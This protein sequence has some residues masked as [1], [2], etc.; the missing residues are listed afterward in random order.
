M[1]VAEEL[2]RTLLLIKMNNDDNMIWP[3]VAIVGLFFF[4]KITTQS[5]QVQLTSL[6]DQQASQNNLWLTVPGAVSAGL[7]GVG[8]LLDSF[9]NLFTDNSITD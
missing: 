6:A 5:Q 1:A 8:S 3:L 2:R 9:D 4:Y 7:T